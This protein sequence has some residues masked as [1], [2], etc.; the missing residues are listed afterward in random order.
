MAV[1]LVLLVKVGSTSSPAKLTGIC[2]EV[3]RL[4]ANVPRPKLARALSMSALVS[5]LSCTKSIPLSPAVCMNWTKFLACN[6]VMPA[7]KPTAPVG[8]WMSSMVSV[9]KSWSWK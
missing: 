2:P 7:Q 1:A 8:A 6:S 3:F 9:V 5:W 4:L